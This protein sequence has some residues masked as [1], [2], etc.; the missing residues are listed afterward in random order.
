[1]PRKLTNEDYINRCKEKC[2]D[3]PIEEYVNNSTK[4][5]HK[6]S[7]CNNIYEQRP[8]NHL[9]GQ[10]CPLCGN[11]KKGLSIKKTTKQYLQECKSK[12]LDLPIES[13]VN[14]LTKIKHICIKGHIYLQA[15]HDHLK[16]F[17]CSICSENKQKTPKEYY[18]LCKSK[19]LDLPIE[20]YINNHTKIKHK[21]SKGH[22]YKQVP[23]DHLYGKGCPICRESHGEKYI[24]NY[25]D[26][27]NINYIPQK[28]FH[29]LKDKTYLSYDFYLPK[30]NILIEYQG[31]QHYESIN[32]KGN[33]KYSNLEKQQEHDKLKREY[34]KNNGYKLLELHYSLD[35]QE[36]VGRYLN[37]M[38]NN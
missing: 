37:M 8:N 6:C 34:A 4:I 31:I 30:Q 13:Y 17:G 1:M 22:I 35:T 9:K 2:F 26:K 14:A 25:L 24:R 36:L 18:K 29:D 19:G 3:L 10:G 28:R 12:G 33:G 23:S 5:K 32:F 20:D 38:F 7:K 27:N 15:P 16:G 21:C 11:N